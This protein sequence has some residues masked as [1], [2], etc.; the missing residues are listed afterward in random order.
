MGSIWSTRFRYVVPPNPKN[1]TLPSHL[2]SLTAG[3]CL[4]Y[5]ISYLNLLDSLFL[6]SRERFSNLT[7]TSS[8]ITNLQLLIIKVSLLHDHANP[9]Y[10]ADYLHNTTF[11]EDSQEV[12]LDYLSRPHSN[13][14]PM[15][16]TKLLVL[17]YF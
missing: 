3:R 4:A 11:L 1:D 6:H 13:H 10:S 15:Q 9:N 14:H 2:P 5:G 17:F 12:F 7:F 16:L 8:L